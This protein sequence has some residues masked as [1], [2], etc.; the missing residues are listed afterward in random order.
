MPST[1]FLWQILQV[2]ST[3]HTSRRGSR[4]SGTWPLAPWCMC[5]TS[6]TGTARPA[7]TG[8]C[9]RTS[10]CDPTPPLVARP[11]CS[12]HSHGNTLF[13]NGSSLQE[14]WFIPTL[15][16]CV[17]AWGLFVCFPST[18]MWFVAY[19]VQGIL[20]VSVEK[21]KKQKMCWILSFPDCCYFRV[22]TVW[23]RR[24]DWVTSN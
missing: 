2:K 17:W 21:E 3:P 7:K 13:D 18:E 4:R 10:S 9:A 5:T 24:G 14:Q 16:V 20:F 15:G 19:V 6:S 11:S 12:I 22:Y 23:G 8:V 1:I